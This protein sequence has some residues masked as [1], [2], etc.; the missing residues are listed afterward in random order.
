MSCTARRSGLDRSGGLRD[1]VTPRVLSSGAPDSAQLDSLCL[2]QQRV[3]KLL[4]VFRRDELEPDFER[5]EAAQLLLHRLGWEF[6]TRYKQS[7]AFYLERKQLPFAC[8][9]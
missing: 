8:H 7:S 3:R 9:L 6:R 4:V 2:L 1:R 5:C